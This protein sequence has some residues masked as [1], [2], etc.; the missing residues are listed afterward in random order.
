[1]YNPYDTN[2][3]KIVCIKDGRVGSAATGQYAI[4]YG[5][6]NIFHFT[7]AKIDGAF[8]FLSDTPT[9]RTATK[10]G[11]ILLQNPG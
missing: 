6:C 1:V 2:T 7:S 9:Y 10:P 4:Q 5:I 3:T 11:R 8:V